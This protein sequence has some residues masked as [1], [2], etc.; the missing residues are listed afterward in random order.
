MVGGEGS[1][2]SLAEALIYERMDEIMS[3]AGL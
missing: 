3:M 1:D 2:D